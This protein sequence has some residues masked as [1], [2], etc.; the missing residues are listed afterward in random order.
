MNQAAELPTKSEQ[1]Q[2]ASTRNFSTQPSK[3]LQSETLTNNVETAYTKRSKRWKLTLIGLIIAL[4][5]TVIVSLDIGYALIPFSEILSILGKQVPILSGHIDPNAFSSVNQAI[6]LDIRLPRILSAVII[7]AALATSGVIFQGV[8]KNPMADPYVLGVSAGASLGT[9]IGMLYGAG[10]SFLGF[11]IVPVAAFIAALV[12]IF[13]VYNI[14]RVGSRVPEMTLLLS[15]IAVTIFLSAI[16]QIMQILA[17]NTKL[18]A[19][20]YWLIGGVTNISWNI[21]WSIFPFIFVSIILSY[22]FARD[23]NMIALGE[24]TAQHLGVN[25]ERTKKLLLALAAMM[26]AAAVSVSGLIGFVGLMIPHI[27][28]L[29]VGPDHRILMPVSVIVGAIFLVVCDAIARIATGATELPVGAITALAGGPF[30]IFLLRKKK[31]S[32]RM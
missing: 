30:F 4:I 28:R 9:G 32:Y 22:F 27:T 20:V 12:T 11:P 21:W 7:G 29:I 23:L 17:P 10:L 16:F 13:V 3:A 6:I 26:T 8:F 14:S 18:H 15:G 25:T 1:L 5:L 24:D 2:P 31:L 19:L